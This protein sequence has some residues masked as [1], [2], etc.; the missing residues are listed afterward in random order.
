M[1]NPP[2][3][4]RSPM[5]LAKEDDSSLPAPVFSFILP[6]HNEESNLEDM[7]GRLMRAGVAVGDAFEI[8]F[9]DDG[10]TDDSAA[11]LQRLSSA[12]SHVRVLHFSRNF[13]HMAALTAG[14]EAARATGAVITLDADGQHPPELIP[15][16]IER[17][18]QGADIVQTIR[19]P[20]ANE[21]PLKNVTSRGFYWLINKLS[22]LELPAGA[23]DFRL[24]DRQ[25]VDALNSLPERQRFLRGLVH[26][27]GFQI[28]NLPYEPAPRV[29]G[30]TK[31][32]VR[33]MMAF[34][35]EG[36]TSFAIRPLRIASVIGLL[37]LVL[38]AAYAFYVL[39][40]FMTGKPLVPGWPSLLLSILFLSGIQ[41]LTL[42]IASEYLGRVYEETKRRPI[43]ILKKTPVNRESNQSS[44]E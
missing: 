27:I 6:V 28:E 40:Q 42:G 4:A 7:A 36:I 1:T 31:Y 16:L 24:L 21:T 15:Q 23:A 32:S 20:S 17:W 14:L 8:V 26:W 3:P 12:D 22:D 19:S 13:G 34:A 25:A 18:R 41:L 33:K 44:R 10:S 9:V 43:Y 11:I 5:T 39:W 38:A 30:Q 2:E 35:F 29:A 37:M